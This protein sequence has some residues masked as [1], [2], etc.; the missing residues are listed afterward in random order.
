[1][2]N[3]DIKHLPTHIELLSPAK[4]LECGIEAIKHGADAIYIGAPKFGARTAAAN[5]I[6]DLEQVIRYAHLFRAKVLIT[7]NT[8]FT[9]SEL[10]EV[11]KLIRQLYHIGADALI[12]QDM[13]I[14]QLDLPPIALHASTQMDNRTPE[15]VKFLE[16]EGFKRVVLA[17]EL[18]L[19]Q[20]A[21]IRKQTQIELEAFVH[22]SLCVSYS[23]Q[24]YLSHACC[25]RSANRGEC[26]QYC[27]LPYSLQD[28]NGNI[29]IDKK[30]LLSL[31]DMDRSDFLYEM[32][33]AGITTFKIEGRLKEVNYVKNVTA[34]Y[35]Q[36]IDLILEANPTHFQRTSVGKSTFFFMPHPKKS[37]NRGKTDYFLY[38]R[39]QDITQFGTPKSIGEE[40]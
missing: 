6:K 11:Q 31:K 2:N 28:T 40:V 10:E 29:L 30:H 15:K 38:N 39:K 18:S 17:R 4:N 23:G 12:I 7:L 16:N 3:Q 20:I 32:M 25:G 33:M 34:F 13:G 1:M 37:F 27:R 14:L 9:D 26:A 8:I 35:R 24:C 21:K 19:E 36:K 5:S 22:G